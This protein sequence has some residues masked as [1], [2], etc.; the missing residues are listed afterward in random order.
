MEAFNDINIANPSVK[1]I[2]H[3]SF[4]LNVFMIFLFCESELFFVFYS[5]I[6]T[7]TRPN[8]PL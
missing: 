2:E 1:F 4:T 3:I 7:S 8:I 6:M 5:K